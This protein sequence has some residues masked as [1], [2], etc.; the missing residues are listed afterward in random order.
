[1]NILCVIKRAGNFL[2]LKFNFS[3][4]QVDTLVKACIVSLFVICKPSFCNLFTF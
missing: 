4:N 3:Y 1:M 2:V